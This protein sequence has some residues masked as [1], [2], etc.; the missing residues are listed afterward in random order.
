MNTTTDPTPA[1]TGPSGISQAA[2][3]A[4]EYAKNAAHEM[5]ATIR[6]ISRNSSWIVK[7]A[8]GASMPHQVSYLLALIT[9]FLHWD[10]LA[11][12]SESIGMILLAVSI[13]VATDLFILNNIKTVGATAAARS[14]KIYALCAM[15]APVGVSGYV[16]FAA[17]GPQLIRWLAAWAVVLIPL[18]EAG[19]AFLRADFVKLEKMETSATENLVRSAEK[20]A[21]QAEDA[22]VTATAVV[23][24]KHV[25]KQRMLAAQK[26]RDL[27]QSA[28]G[29]S[30]AALMR[31]TGCGRG[32]A[33]KAIELANAA[34]TDP[35]AV[36]V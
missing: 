20:L 9:P 15:L 34:A 4:V 13:P 29:I 16:N 32:A 31:A 12:V 30:I 18:S 26:A 27:A 22:Q 21:A 1:T 24:P 5:L 3:F 10:S 11:A 8:L 28:S 19:R 14:S 35:V 33:K 7:I 23:D 25:N 17:P 36:A 6:D 2:I